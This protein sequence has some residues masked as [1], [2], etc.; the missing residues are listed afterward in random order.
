MYQ[1]HPTTVPSMSDFDPLQRYLFYCARGVPRFSVHGSFYGMAGFVLPIKAGNGKCI[2]AIFRRF[3]IRVCRFSEQAVLVF[4]VT[5]RSG[6]DCDAIG[7]IGCRHAL[8]HLP[9][10]LMRYLVV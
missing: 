9:R 8:E 2:R 1:V 5:C 3:L 10:M 6:V 7:R 4:G